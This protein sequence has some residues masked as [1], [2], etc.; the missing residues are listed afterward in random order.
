MA[1]TAHPSQL[2]TP[3][4]WDAP[5]YIS[6]ISIFE[7]VIL[8]SSSASAMSRPWCP[9]SPDLV[10][11]ILPSIQTVTLELPPKHR[12]KSDIRVGG[13]AVADTYV[14]P[15]NAPED[16]QGVKGVH[17]LDLFAGDEGAQPQLLPLK[18]SVVLGGAEV[19]GGF[20]R[21][22]SG[23]DFRE[24]GSVRLHDQI[25]T[26]HRRRKRDRKGQRAIPDPPKL[27][28][29]RIPGKPPQHEAS[30]RISQP[31]RFRRADLNARHRAGIGVAHRSS[32]L[33]TLG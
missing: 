3:G 12:G 9:G 28:P 11:C 14:D 25:E 27:E 24:H 6:T 19:L 13:V 17:P 29:N 22:S 30:Q 31:P 1:M 32:E 10:S 8:A 21:A 2:N 26:A 16:L 33:D 7:G 23:A 5:R 18:E 4:I 15:W 20:G